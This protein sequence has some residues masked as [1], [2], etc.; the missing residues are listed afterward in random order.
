MIEF[1]LGLV[2]LGIMLFIIEAAEPG[3]FIAIPAGVLLVLGVIAVLHPDILTTIWTPLIVAVLVIP[4]MMISMKFYQKISPPTKPTTTMS[5]SLVGKT[6]KVMQRV[7]PDEITGKVKIE[8]Q[9]WSATSEKEEIE[10]G[11]KVIVTDSRGVHIVVKKK[12]E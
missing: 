10:I 12:E 6:G 11:E 3:F 7:K 5:S 1:G 2:I 9:I 8:H 4:L